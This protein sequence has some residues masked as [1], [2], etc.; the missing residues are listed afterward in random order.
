MHERA[1]LLGFCILTS[2]LS[3]PSKTLSAPLRAYLVASSSH[4]ALLVH[5]SWACILLSYVFAY[6]LNIPCLSTSILLLLA[7][8]L[9]SRAGSAPR[10]TPGLQH[11]R[12]IAAP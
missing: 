8:S 7:H 9:S 1:S 5:A 4:L 12:P 11:C 3:C 10:G 2:N 6:L